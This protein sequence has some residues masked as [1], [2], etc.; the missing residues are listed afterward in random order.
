VG[1]YAEGIFLLAIAL[2][3]LQAAAYLWRSRLLGAWTGAEARLAEIVIDL[4]VLIC[5]SEFLGAVH[6]YRIGPVVGLLAAIG[7]AGIWA[8]K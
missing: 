5:V 2:A 6:L 8:A 7:V 3:P 1:R 4:T